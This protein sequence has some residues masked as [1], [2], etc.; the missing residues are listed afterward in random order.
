[1]KKFN[2]FNEIITADKSSLLQ[3][4][5]TSKVFGININ[6]EIKYEPFDDKEILIYRGKPDIVENFTKVLG[7]N[8]QLVEDENRVLIKAFS[9]WQELIGINT[10]RASSVILNLS[11]LKT[12]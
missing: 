4:I 3:A 1:M 10:P 11:K 8:Y 2:L 12:L 7:K 6:G 5:N 9:N